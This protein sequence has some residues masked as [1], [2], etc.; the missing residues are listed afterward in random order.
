MLSEAKRTNNFEVI[1]SKTLSYG[2]R[3]FDKTPEMLKE[4]K[5]AKVVDAGEK[6]LLLLSVA[7]VVKNLY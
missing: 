1:M 2:E 3:C 4:L 6:D 7:E 5:E